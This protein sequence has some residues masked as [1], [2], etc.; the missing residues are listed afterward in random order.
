MRRWGVTAV[1]VVITLAIAGQATAGPKPLCHGKTATIVGSFEDDEINGTPSADVIW[2]DEGDDIISAGRGADLICAGRDDDEVSGGP[3]NDIIRGYGGEDTLE[4]GPGDD[5]IFG[6]ST[7]DDLL[8]DSGN[9]L[10]V[11]GSKGWGWDWFFGGRGN[12]VIK[13]DDEAFVMYWYAPRGV[14]LDLR[15]GIARGEGHDVFKGGISRVMGSHHPDR[16]LGDRTSNWMVGGSFGS[17]ADNDGAD[18]VKGR[19]G[20]DSLAGLDG[21]DLVWGGR[22]NDWFDAH[23]IQHGNPGH[24]V[25]RGGSGDDVTDYGEWC[26]SRKCRDPLKQGVNVNLTTG[27]MESAVGSEELHSIENVIGSDAADHVIGSAAANF[28][29]GDPYW[30]RNGGLDVIRG[31]PGAD[32]IWGERYAEGG[33]AGNQPDRFFGDG[34]DDI[35]AGD[36]GDDVLVGGRGND[37]VKGGAEAD[38]ISGGPGND[39]LNGENGMDRLRAGE[40]ND[41]VLGSNDS[42]E[43]FAG[44]GDDFLDGGLDVDLYDGGEG[45]DNCKIE[46][47]EVPVNCETFAALAGPLHQSSFSAPSPAQ[48]RGVRPGW[49]SGDRR[50]RGPSGR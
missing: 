47:G 17:S 3:G 25:I 36:G 31:G 28:L 48:L 14:D 19:G 20:G 32:T 4:G 45:E 22:G 7:R 35:L 34:G 10:L 2:A 38:E 27:E 43:L 26:P 15:K 1:T 6:G 5:K 29:I 11:G 16:L 42:D 40:G 13:G 21:D 9:D 50:S 37:E 30:N 33:S 49:R 18:I 44:P 46:P 12:D 41:Q 8:G 24:D 39:F 23:S